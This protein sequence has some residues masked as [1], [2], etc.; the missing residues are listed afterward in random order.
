MIN[1][2]E[3]AMYWMDEVYLG[4]SPEERVKYRV[5]E[6][7]NRRWGSPEEFLKEC[8]V[9]VEKVKEPILRMR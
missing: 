3:L 5:M 4:L 9:D 1:S 2:I 7:I 8:K 6:E